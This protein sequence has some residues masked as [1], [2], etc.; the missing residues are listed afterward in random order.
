MSERNAPSQAQTRAP[1][2]CSMCR[3]IGHD[4]CRCPSAPP[5]VVENSLETQRTTDP[6]PRQQPTTTTRAP[7]IDKSS[8]VY[9]V[10]DLETTGFSKTKDY[11]IEIAAGLLDQ[12]GI[13]MEDGKFQSYVRPP[14]NIPHFISELTGITNQSVANAYDFA[15][16]GRSFLEFIFEKVIELGQ[17]NESEITVDSI[18]PSC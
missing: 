11:I 16:V 13:V 14:C 6:P 10:F 18:S 17:T 15:V 3:Q 1:R 12:N 8:C 4:K 7:R 2:T 5:A 9:I